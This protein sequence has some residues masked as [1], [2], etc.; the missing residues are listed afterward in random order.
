MLSARIAEA[1]LSQEAA[2]AMPNDDWIKAQLS[3]LSPLL[4]DDTRRAAILLRRLVSR[5]RAEAIVAPGKS[6]EFIRLHVQVDALNLLKEALGGKLPESIMATAT[7]HSN[8]GTEFQL[9]LGKPT[10]R[11]VAAPEIAAMRARDMTWEEIGKRTGLGTGNAHNV[12]KRW[13]DAQ[14][15]ECRDRA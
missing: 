7:S 1:R 6:R 12:W 3:E 10:R 15:K 9:D 14:P 11:D 8:E 5:V 4:D 13:V 2:V